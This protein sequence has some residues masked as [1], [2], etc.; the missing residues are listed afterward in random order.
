MI[1]KDQPAATEN[2]QLMRSWVETPMGS[3][4]NQMKMKGYWI[5]RPQDNLNPP[6][7]IAGANGAT[8]SAALSIT[9]TASTQRW[10]LMSADDLQLF[11]LAVPSAVHEV[12]SEKL[13]TISNVEGGIM[14]VAEGTAQEHLEIYSIAGQLLKIVDVS[15]EKVFVP[16][17]RGA[18]IVGDQKVMVR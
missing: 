9:N 17:G 18:Y 16:L 12:K 15:V 14:I 11:D 4:N 3:G 6:C 7:L 1:A 5:M 13:F 10:L 2:F 8:A